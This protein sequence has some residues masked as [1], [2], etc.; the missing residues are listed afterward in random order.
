MG[1]LLLLL[2]LTAG[3]LGG[4]R[5]A[6]IPYDTDRTFNVSQATCGV[7][8]T[9]IRG[10]RLCDKTAHAMY[11][12]AIVTVSMS[13]H[14]GGTN[15]PCWRSALRGVARA[16][17]VSMAYEVGMAVIERNRWGEAGYGIGLNDHLA[18][19]I[20][21]VAAAGAVCGVRALIGH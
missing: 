20:G 9:G 21:S 15:E 17:V 7:Q 18:A 14:R 2:G 16:Q 1:E 10:L 11:G 19:T 13:L 12:S 3:V 5:L 8:P 4:G 6:G